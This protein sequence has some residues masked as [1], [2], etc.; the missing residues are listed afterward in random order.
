VCDEFRAGHGHTEASLTVTPVK[1]AIL[2]HSWATGTPFA[3]AAFAGH[4]T[5][6]ART[7]PRRSAGSF[8]R[9]SPQVGR[10]HT[11]SHW[12]ATSSTQ[13]T[14]VAAAGIRYRE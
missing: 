11:I 4:P 6:P 2:A 5:S 1:R 9:G 7:L 8:G 14:K 3:G 13:S 10:P 12:R